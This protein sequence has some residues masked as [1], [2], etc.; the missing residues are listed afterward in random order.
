MRTRQVH[1]FHLTLFFS[2]CSGCYSHFYPHWLAQK[3]L[4]LINEVQFKW[5]PQPPYCTAIVYKPA[6]YF[7]FLAEPYPGNSTSSL[8]KMLWLR[9]WLI[10]NNLGFLTLGEWRC[11]SVWDSCTSD[12]TGLSVLAS[13]FDA[14][15]DPCLSSPIASPLCHR[16]ESFTR[17]LRHMFCWTCFQF[18][19]NPRQQLPLSPL[20]LFL[21]VEDPLN[22]PFGPLHHLNEWK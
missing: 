8:L 10:R 9:H 11:S 2:G 7:L 14:V 18:F 20:P 1:Q 21:L 13:L 3:K 22:S 17:W 15:M 12:F 19:K 4:W 5:I 16:C 6:S